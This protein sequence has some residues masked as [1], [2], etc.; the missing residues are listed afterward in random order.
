MD[1]DLEYIYEQYVESPVGLSDEEEYSDETMMMQA[2]IG[3]ARRSMFS[4]SRALS[5][6][7]SAQPQQGNE[8][9][10]YLRLRISREKK[11]CQ[12]LGFRPSRPTRERRCRS[13]PGFLVVVPSLALS[14]VRWL[15]ARQS[16]ATSSASSTEPTAPRKDKKSPRSTAVDRIGDLPDEIIHHL[17]SFLPA[18][19][20]VRT[21]VLARRWRHLWKSAT[22]LRIVG[23]E[24]VDTVQELRKFVDHLLILRGHAELHLRSRSRSSR[25]R[26]C[27]T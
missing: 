22:G 6:V 23:I 8:Q 15:C 7:M 9:R 11:P 3:D 16:T 26:T 17:L 20:A 12:R 21:S 14:S 13:E 19:E 2:V 1:S 5:R 27:P 18:Q 10:Q 25:K 24:G 4:V